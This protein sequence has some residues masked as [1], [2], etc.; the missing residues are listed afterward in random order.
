MPPYFDDHLD[1]L[2]K[3]GTDCE[4]ILWPNWNSLDFGTRQTQATSHISWGR[5]DMFFQPSSRPNSSSPIGKTSSHIFKIMKTES[6]V[7]RGG[8]WRELVGEV[9]FF[10]L[11]LIHLGEVNEGWTMIDQDCLNIFGSEQWSQT[12]GWHFPL[13]WL[14]LMW[15]LSSWQPPLIPIKSWVVKSP[16]PPKFNSSPPKHIFHFGMVYFQG[17]RWTSGGYIYRH[18]PGVYITAQVPSLTQELSPP[19]A[20]WPQVATVPSWKKAMGFRLV[21]WCCWC[22][23]LVFVW[24][25]LLGWSHTHTLSPF[26]HSTFRDLGQKKM[27]LHDVKLDIKLEINIGPWVSPCTM[28]SQ[29]TLIH[30]LVTGLLQTLLRWTRWLNYIC[31][32]CWLGVLTRCS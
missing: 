2:L 22:S 4:K 6:P 25:V 30:R 28:I 21:G 19:E 10:N 3:S 24:L 20:A 14:L 9:V 1:L 11:P 32:I 27:R 7:F 18:Q 13:Y 23:W 5:V 8:P 26:L 16:T 15:I 17:L 12:L 31:Y 29:T